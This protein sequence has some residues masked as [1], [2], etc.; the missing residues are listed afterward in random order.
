MAST[1]SARSAPPA[2]AA[3][4]GPAG[5][6]R[7]LARARAARPA[8]EPRPAHAR[9]VLLAI[10]VVAAV[11]FAWDIQHSA[12]H[13]FY[14]ETARSMSESWWG[15]LF[16]SFDPGNSITIDKLPG[17]LWPQAL[18]VRIF[19]FHPWALT[20]PQVIEGVLSVAILHRAVRRWAGENAALLA[21][22][23]FALT[24]AVAGLFRTEVE[25]PAFTLCVLLA[26]EAALRA[27]REARLRPLL[28]AGAWV[29]LGFQAK[30]LEAWAVLPALCLLYLLSAP[31]T[32]RRRLAHLSAAGALCLA[33]SASWVLLVTFT[34]AQDRPFVDGTTNNSAVSQVVGY[35]FVNRFSNLHVN[36]A[37]TGSVAVSTMAGTA[38]AP[39]TGHTRPTAAQWVKMFAPS[40][41]S[42]IGWLYPTAALAT[43]CGLVWRRGRPRTDPLRA[44]F[45]LW[46]VWLVTYFLVFSAGAIGG[47]TYY[48]GVLAVPLAALFGAGTVQFW[49]GW[50]RGGRS[51]A[52]ALPTAVVGTVAWS[53]AIAELFPDFLPWLAPAAVALAVAALALLARGRS[54]A[55]SRVAVD[56]GPAAGSGATAGSGAAVD[57]G[58]VA[59]TGGRTARRRTALVGLGAGLV[60]MLLPSAAWASSVL[61]PAYGHSGM[62]S[63]GPVVN[64]HRAVAHHP[65]PS[66]K[67]GHKGHQAAD[68][69]YDGTA[70]SP[71]QRR[72]LDYARA[73]RDGAAFLFAT[74]SWRTASPYILH[75]GAPVLPM[76]GFTGTAPTPTAAGFRHLVATGQLRYVVL[77]GPATD[78]GRA[79]GPWVR[80]H[81]TPVPG[82]AYRLYRCTPA[83]AGAGPG[84]RG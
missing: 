10:L 35:N 15:F 74:T 37:D 84:A 3:P 2:I 12:F 73:H 48:L 39:P 11:L 7:L 57:A 49:R 19:G 61:D 71:A 8:P 72:L 79:I 22:G 77:G 33:A 31:A 16:G 18:S 47:H 30:M 56:G 55:R 5:A 75:A 21:A 14:S 26:A 63:T 44:G 20:L 65:K 78:P 80:G 54:A 34:P 59:R 13:A 43:V 67:S 23:A 69:A 25:D 36:A 83:S 41:V 32:L 58:P 51:R 45:V 60:A 42:Q 29:G 40:I 24:P 82:Q 50:L 28:A 64:R 17:F 68:R 1:T 81:C 76:G 4:T 52:W 66:G 27:A 9:P 6:G 46:G 53:A 62:G 70:L 38:P